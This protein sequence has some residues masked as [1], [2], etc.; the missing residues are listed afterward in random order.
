[1]KRGDFFQPGFSA[2]PF[3][4]EARRRAGDILLGQDLRETN[5]GPF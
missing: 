1:M 5:T 4:E 2:R 3:L